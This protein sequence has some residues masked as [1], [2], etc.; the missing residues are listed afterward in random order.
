[1][2]LVALQLKEWI[3]ADEYFYDE[4]KEKEETLK[5][6]LKVKL[7]S[8]PQISERSL[9]ILEIFKKRQLRGMKT[10]KKWLLQM[11]PQK[12]KISRNNSHI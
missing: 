1:M 12:K 2:G 7:R 8:Y 6:E 3:E 5:K 4:L 9:T 11:Y 10:L